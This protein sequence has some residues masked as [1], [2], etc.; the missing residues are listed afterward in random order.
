M[1]YLVT[2]CA[3][4]PTPCTKLTY[5]MH[6]DCPKRNRSCTKTNRKSFL[7]YILLKRQVRV[8]AAR[9]ISLTQGATMSRRTLL[10]AGA[11]GALAAAGWLSP[12]LAADTIR[13]ASSIRCPARWRFPRHR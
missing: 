8:F 11:V 13:S 2:D 6:R 5:S 3:V 12:T 7:A 10:K 4:K 9:L 1:H